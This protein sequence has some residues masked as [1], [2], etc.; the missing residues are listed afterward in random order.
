MKS[1]WGIGLSVVLV[2]C[3]PASVVITPS[4]IVNIVPTNTAIVSSASPVAIVPSESVPPTDTLSIPTAIAPEVETIAP[5]ARQV[6]LSQ[7]ALSNTT[8][9]ILYYEPSQSLRIMSRQDI[10]PQRIP[11]IVSEEWL[12]AGIKI[13]PNQ[14][15]FIYQV[16]KGMKDGIAYYDYWIS[17]IDGKVQQ[18]AASN[19]SGRTAVRWVSNE[20]IELWFYSNGARACPERVSIVNPFAQ[21]VSIAPEIPPS[22][23]P[24]CFFDLSTNPDRSKMIYLNEDG[25]W[26]IYDFDTAQSQAVFP[27]L[28]KSERFD[29]WPRYIQWSTTGI[30]IALPQ[31]E[32]VDFIIDLPIT[33]A[34]ENNVAWNKVLLPDGNKI[35]NEMF[36]WWALDKGLVGFDLVQSDFRYA[37]SGDETPPSNFVVLDLKSSTLYDYNLDRARI[38]DAQK[39]SDYFIH[40]SADNRFLAWTIF[41]PPGMGNP[42]ETVVLDR[43]TGQ[44]ARIKGFEVFG[45]GEVNSP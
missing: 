25:S 40:A 42:I 17:S 38:G 2:A 27:W 11:N 21:E 16:S 34:S 5:H 13:S 4:S 24:Q 35:Y 3:S 37:E 15:W 18:I 8:R 20:Q 41:N 33:N 6:E 29:L 19:V 1:L 22:I 28:S 14:N 32:S 30:T 36:S 26:N 39:V 12:F 7:L 31:E 23:S 45:W 9:L 10:Q 44:I 43:Q